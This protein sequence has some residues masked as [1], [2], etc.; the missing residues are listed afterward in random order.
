M[1]I[2]HTADWHLGKK[3]CGFSRHEEQVEALDEICQIA[4]KQNVDLV[5]IAGDLFDG[6][7]PSSESTELFYKTLHRLSKDGT[8]AVVAIAGNHDSPE[9]IAAPEPLA[10]S[11][12]I[13]LIGFPDTEVPHFE[14][15]NG[16]KLLKSKP[17]FI[18]L[19][20]PN[21]DY[22]VRIILTAFANEVRL[23]K[24][25]G[26]EDNILELKDLLAHTWKDLAD[27]HCDAKG[28]NILM[29]HLYFVPESGNI[30]PESDD[31]RS[32]AGLG[33]TEALPVS[34]FPS[35]IQYVALGHIHKFWKVSNKQVPAVYA[36][37][38]LCYSLSEAGQEKFVIIVEA[39]PNQSIEYQKIKL[40]SGKPVL[41]KT[42]DSV[43]EAIV[44]L[45]QN[46]NALV[47]LT[48]VSEHY[49]KAEDSKRL[50][51]SHQG[52]LDLIPQSKNQ[53]LQSE[54]K[55]ENIDI[56]MDIN[57]LFKS[58]FKHKKGIEPSGELN[59]LFFEINNS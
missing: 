1:K 57:E 34:I 48:I 49:L 35:Q 11:C 45:D 53:N 9:R 7:N 47:E 51:A 6:P 17:G 36:S 40:D 32:I 12:G 33:G 58:F 22:P 25:F 54:N 5:L 28:I 3:L 27:Q 20:L 14:T 19:K 21:V 13:V 46:S 38:P 37:S 31:E 44:W 18:E 56:Q 2:L 10:L 41:R 42:F 16:V 4:E 23:K 29:T 30:E 50:Y 26:N 15:D 39:E 24:Y 55:V 59:Q 52:I 8:K 43:D